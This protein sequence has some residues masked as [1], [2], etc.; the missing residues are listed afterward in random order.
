[1]EPSITM[2]I[3]LVATS[4]V[5]TS[6]LCL[7]ALIKR[8]EIPGA[9]TF[10]LYTATQA[11]YIFAVSFEMASAT[12]EQIKGWTIVEYIGISAAPAL[13]LILV[14]QYI[15]K[16][17]TRTMVAA[18]FIIPVITFVMVATNDYHHLFYKTIF[19]RN[20]TTM[21]MTDIEIGQWYIVHGAYTFGCML[22]AVVLLIRKWAKTKKAHRLQL[23]ILIIGQF[24]PMVSAFVYLMGLTPYSIDPVPLVLCVTSAVYIWAMVSTRVMTIVPI[25][26]ESI[27]ES[28]QEGVIVMDYA[29]RLIDFN[30]A[31]HK[32]VPNLTLD[33]IGLTLDEAWIR[34][35]GTD[36]P[37]VVLL[38][39]TKQGEIVWRAAGGLPCYYQ[40]RSSIVRGRSGE[41]L[42]SLLM[43][44]DVTEQRLLQDQLKQ[45]A[46]Y[47]GLTKL[48]NRTE[49]IHRSKLLLDEAAQTK[50]PVAIVLFDIDH[51][52]NINDTYGHET[53]DRAIQHVVRLAREA[54]DPDV[55]FGRYGGEEFVFIMASYSLNETAELAERIRSLLANT[56][57]SSTFGS[58]VITASFGLAARGDSG[59]TLE[60]LLR[61]ADMA[62][63]QA[64][65]AGRNQVRS[66]H[67]E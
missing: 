55:L 13:G 65:R 53:G 51:F 10:V 26:K 14:L 59:D 18:F 46:Y 41:S 42:G 28:M 32:M 9:L 49:F 4:G 63:Y 15:G 48:L 39:G 23:V 52:K 21:P 16:K 24:L 56:P 3:S 37:A 22:A 58:I 25:A 5:F 11:I 38:D 40:V 2:L 8:S 29:N 64:K 61:D 33:L 43:F 6:F 67:N 31:I 66:F 20:D 50:I 34:L 30:G 35:T 45:L 27:F 17:L 54:L 62:L 57:L 12:I 36:F 1:M 60:A 47:D 19:F 7:Y 44:I